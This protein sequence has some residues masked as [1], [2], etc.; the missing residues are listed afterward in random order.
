MLRIAVLNKDVVTETSSICCLFS[1]RALGCLNLML[2][3]CSAFAA[4]VDNLAE[5]MLTMCC[6]LQQMVSVAS[7]R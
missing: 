4:L 5:V 1:P 7:T 6:Y 2:K 3:E